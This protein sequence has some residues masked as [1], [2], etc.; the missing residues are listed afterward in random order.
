MK[1]ILVTTRDEIEE[2]C[3]LVSEEF[4]KEV[5]LLILISNLSWDEEA[6]SKAFHDVIN[7]VGNEKK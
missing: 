3:H 6:K 1:M 4:Y 5:A 7:M 2:G